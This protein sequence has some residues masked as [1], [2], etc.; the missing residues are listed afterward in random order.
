[1]TTK[2][3]EFEYTFEYDAEEFPDYDDEDFEQMA[4]D[5]LANNIHDLGYGVVK[6][7]EDTEE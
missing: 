3:V 5:V 6:T 7:I 1:M 2:R 4:F